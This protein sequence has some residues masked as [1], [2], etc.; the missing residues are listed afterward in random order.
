MSDLTR[1]EE[2][3]K[4]DK[5]AEEANKKRFAEEKAKKKREKEERQELYRKFREYNMRIERDKQGNIISMGAAS[6]GYVKKYAH[7]GGV[8]K[9]KLSDY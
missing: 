6:G 9:T 2:I 1:G 4:E 7:G 5:E 3:A 8:R